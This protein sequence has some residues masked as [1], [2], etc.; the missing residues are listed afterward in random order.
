[1]EYLWDNLVVLR[2]CYNVIILP[3]Y[4]PTSCSSIA[5]NTGPAFLPSAVRF[6]S[7]HRRSPAI[8][9]GKTCRALALLMRRAWYF[10]IHLHCLEWLVELP[11]QVLHHRWQDDRKICPITIRNHES[12]HDGIFTEN[13]LVYGDNPLEFVELDRQ[14][15][16]YDDVAD[17]RFHWNNHRRRHSNLKNRFHIFSRRKSPSWIEPR[18]SALIVKSRRPASNCQ[19]CVNSTNACRPSVTRSILNVVISKLSV[20]ST[21][22]V[23]VPCFSPL[24]LIIRTCA[25]AN[26]SFICSGV[27]VVAKSTSCGVIPIRISRTAPPA[28]RIS[29]WLLLN[30]S[31]SFRSDGVRIAWYS[32]V[33][34]CRVVN[35]V[36]EW[37]EVKETELE[38]RL[39]VR[40]NYNGDIVSSC[41]LENEKAH[42]KGKRNRRWCNNKTKGNNTSLFLPSFFSCR[43]SST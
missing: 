39:W 6:S 38:F 27:A 28:I 2:G 7:I 5:F 24:A 23:I 25:L 20:S 17:H 40:S 42:R 10:A 21:R 30:S 14:R 16:E 37:S 1:M 31:A 26:I 41:H 19:S 13:I 8:S 32:G 11:D 15:N 29:C 34:I 43:G 12:Q 3:K 36:E 18:K 9:E 22:A 35:I 4:C 33:S